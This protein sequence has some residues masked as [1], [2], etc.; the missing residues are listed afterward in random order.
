MRRILAGII[1]LAL[2]IGTL[3]APAQEPQWHAVS[4]GAPVAAPVAT[5]G[6]PQ[7]LPSSAPRVA[8]GQADERPPMP[9]GPAPNADKKEPLPPPTPFDAPAPNAVPDGVPFAMNGP[10]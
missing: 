2:G 4:L 3:N 8:R 10:V 1:G 9:L 5:L 6:A 7:P